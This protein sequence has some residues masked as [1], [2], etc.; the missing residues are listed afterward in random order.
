MSRTDIVAEWLAASPWADWTIIPIAGDASARHY[1]RLTK[2]ETE[3]VILMDAPVD[4][5]GPQDAFVQMSAHLRDLQLAAPRIRAWDQLLGLM[6]LD[7][8]GRVDV[9]S[10]VVSTPDEEHLIYDVAVDV[11]R[12]IGSAP[13]PTGVPYMDAATAVKMIDLAFDWAAPHTAVNLRTDIESKLLEL[14]NRVAPHTSTLSLRDY[15]AQNLIWRPDETGLDRLGLLD[16]Q[17]A[18]VTHPAYD[19]ASLLRDARRDVPDTLTIPLVQRL[20]GA[21]FDQM[22]EAFHVFALQRNLRIL[23]IFHK[24]AQTAGKTN[25]LDLIPRV[26]RYIALDLEAP[27]TA[28]LAP[29]IKRAFLDTSS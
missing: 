11:L 28:P 4:T 29:L 21:D 22:L 14:L 23:G 9:A 18:I 7:D 25:Y 19:L 26:R 3:S 10:H 1:A 12:R 24:L 27:I 6:V 5:C 8:L 13:A 17:D 15:H 2:S 16:F 20:A